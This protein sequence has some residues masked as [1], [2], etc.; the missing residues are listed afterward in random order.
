MLF[1][2]DYFKWID[3]QERKKKLGRKMKCKLRADVIEI[4]CNQFFKKKKKKTKLKLLMLRSSAE[5]VIE[6]AIRD[7]IYINCLFY[8]FVVVIP[9][10][11]GYFK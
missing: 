4:K 5:I 9:R 2:L 7:I 1:K 6:N 11:L 3:Q 8:I 10:E